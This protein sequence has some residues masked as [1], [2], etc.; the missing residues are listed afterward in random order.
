MS[1]QIQRLVRSSCA[2]H[3]EAHVKDGCL[4]E[5]DGLLTCRYF[6]DNSKGARCRY[7]ETSVLPAD[8]GLEA[9]Y[10]GN[11]DK[12]SASC[13]MC[14]KPYVKTSNRQR[15]CTDC[16][17]RAQTDAKRKRDARYREKVMKE[18]TL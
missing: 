16:R 8:C 3:S 7:F 9:R 11:A 1:D 14:R 17:D 10:Y 18:T 6:R 15:Y 4:I 13:A 5:P 12:D 2:N